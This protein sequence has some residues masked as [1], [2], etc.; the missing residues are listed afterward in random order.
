[1]GSINKQL[2]VPR[3]HILVAIVFVD[4]LSS[5]GDRENNKGFSPWICVL[6]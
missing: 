5:Q 6:I 4:M 2:M 1:L 3:S